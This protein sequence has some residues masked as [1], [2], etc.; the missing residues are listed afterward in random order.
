MIF[1]YFILRLMSYFFCF[2]VDTLSTGFGHRNCV[3]IGC[4]NR[5]QRLRKCNLRSGF[6][7]KEGI[8]RRGQNT[9]DTFI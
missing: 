4:P 1:A 5:G 9:P 7:F 8:G 2:N 6:F 3:V